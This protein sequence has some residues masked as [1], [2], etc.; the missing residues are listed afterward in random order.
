MKAY[1]KFIDISFL[2][3]F[4]SCQ[5]SP[6]PINYYNEECSLCQ[7]TISDPKYGAELITQKGKIY[8][9]DSI[10][11][12]ITFLHNFKSEEVNSTWVTDFSQP[13]KFIKSEKAIFLKSDELESPMGLN[14]CAFESKDS[15]NTIKEKLGGEVLSWNDLINFVKHE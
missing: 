7:M 3:I 8:K 11:C 13:Q 12:L 1:K 15:L 9:F 10:E 14:V 2:F 5:K 4:L 6:E